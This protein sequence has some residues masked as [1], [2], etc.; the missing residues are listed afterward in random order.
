[1]KK[2]I[3]YIHA[4][5]LLLTLNACNDFFELQVPPQPSAFQS[6]S[7]FELTA[8]GAY[9]AAFTNDNYNE[10]GWDNIYGYD[11][12][13]DYC[14]SDLARY[15]GSIHNF[16]HIINNDRSFS[17]PFGSKLDVPYLSAYRAIGVC[18]STLD[19]VGANDGNPFP[20]ATQKDNDL[21]VK[22][23]IGEL[24]FMRAF[25][26]FFLVR[27]F[28]PN[29]VP[30]G[31]N[32]FKKIA[33]RKTMAS[34]L[35]Q[36][37]SPVRG[38]TQ[39]IY[40]FIVADLEKAKTLLPERFAEG[41]N[42]GYKYGRANK[43]VAEAILAR[44]YMLM[45]RFDSSSGAGNALENL[46][47]IID[48]GGYDLEP[49][50][51]SNF[52]RGTD[53][54]ATANKEI[55]WELFAAV[56][57]AHNSYT[58]SAMTHF[59][60]CGMFRVGQ[61]GGRSV[62]EFSQN[63]WGQYSLNNSYLK[64]KLK[65]ITDVPIDEEPTDIAKNDKRFNQLYYFYYKYDP[66]AGRKNITN[67]KSDCQNGCDKEKHSTIWVDKHYRA[68]DARNQNTPI[69]RYAEI[70]IHK[71]AILL[72]N[73]DKVGAA[74][75]LDKITKRAWAGAPSAYVPVTDATITDEMLTTEYIKELAGE[76]TWMIYLHAF[77]KPIPQGD[78]KDNYWMV[79]K[80]E[81]AI[82]P[83]YSNQYWPIPASEDLFN[84]TN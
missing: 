37:L 27:T 8:M 38:S 64:K 72:K 11:V 33:L 16:P 19:Y 58:P 74:K 57:P 81:L 53:N 77:K 52:N 29:Y 61:S 70:L 15:V 1:M 12:V 32:S 50:P 26:Y 62:I 41:M 55:I 66:A 82:L 51:Y 42:P 6:V 83:P 21:N 76:G 43:Y 4:L 46:N 84:K 48:K 36:A 68:L 7:N 49:E 10:I 22:R 40:D 20:I 28:H 44:V 35:D 14:S 75:E 9:N 60:K 17:Q 13:L 25:S 54:Y 31:D 23:V 18:N 3:N 24:H 71:A 65:W 79:D 47:D 39:E 63:S 56:K 2:Y 80:P 59:S 5:I 73:G 45:G 67:L 69:V 34:D 30:G 78:H